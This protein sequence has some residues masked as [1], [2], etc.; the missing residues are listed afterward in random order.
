[1]HQKVILTKFEKT[2]S[3]KKWAEGGTANKLGE[4]RRKTASKNVITKIGQSKN[5]KTKGKRA[6]KNGYLNTESVKKADKTC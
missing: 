1:M 3:E 4:L 2:G 6:V 5:V